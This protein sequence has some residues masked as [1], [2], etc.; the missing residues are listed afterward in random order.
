MRKAGALRRGLLVLCGLGSIGLAFVACTDT[1][2][3]RQVRL[4]TQTADGRILGNVMVRD[5]SGA[6]LGTTDPITGHLVI[7]VPRTTDDLSLWLSPQGLDPVSLSHA[8]GWLSVPAEVGF[9]HS[10]DAAS[11]TARLKLLPN[12]PSAAKEGK[13]EPIPA[14]PA[15]RDVWRSVPWTESDLPSGPEELAAATVLGSV[16]ADMASA[17]HAGKAGG[18][19]HS[20]EGEAQVSASNQILFGGSW[21]GMPFL[22]RIG[23]L[24]A[25]DEQVWRALKAAHLAGAAGALRA[26]ESAEAIRDSADPSGHS[27]GGSGHADRADVIETTSAQ[28]AQDGAAASRAGL[29][30]EASGEMETRS[31][32]TWPHSIDGGALEAASGDA[33]TASPLATQGGL[34]RGEKSQS[35]SEPA[36][37]LGLRTQGLSGGL[38][39][40][41]E[42]R[43]FQVSTFSGQPVVGALVSLI[44]TQKNWELAF[45]T[46]NSEGVAAGL[47]PSNTPFQLLRVEHAVSGSL[48]SPVT[49][50]SLSKPARVTFPA[51]DAGNDHPEKLGR[52]PHSPFSVSFRYPS[53]GRWKY[54]RGGSVEIVPRLINPQDDARSAA[55]VRPPLAPVVTALQTPMAWRQQMNSLSHFV[56]PASHWSNVD[57]GAHPSYSYVFR[58]AEERFSGSLP[59]FT[60]PDSS[61]PHLEIRALHQD[62]DRPRTTIWYPPSRELQMLDQ[63]LVGRFQRAI[64]ARFINA[65]VFLPVVPERVL[66]PDGE[67]DLSRFDWRSTPLDPEL[68]Y[69]V[70]LS[71]EKMRLNLEWRNREGRV[72]SSGRLPFPAGRPPEFFAN[73]VFNTIEENFPDELIVEVRSRYVSKQNSA[74]ESQP[75]EGKYLSVSTNREHFKGVVRLADTFHL[76]VIERNRLQAIATLRV[77][78]VEGGTVVLDGWSDAG[79]E[80]PAGPSFSAL[81]SRCP[82]LK[83]LVPNQDTPQVLAESD[84]DLNATL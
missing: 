84:F 32:S 4:I 47:V 39:F 53:H 44:S 72:C 83:P 57:L 3:I 51:P 34:S 80:L 38:E 24:R 56:V 28:S 79:I 67:L 22:G 55:S 18:M 65:R 11:H 37:A 6:V 20:P 2:E 58:F 59:P 33:D 48:L 7:Q 74:H 9:F 43:A 54:F 50:S 1:Q 5:P 31:G 63:T 69:V 8:P 21:A 66:D 26:S 27:E 77:S 46:T 76:Q 16:D 81:L 71:I 29:G 35:A 25:I 42:E 52:V 23:E 19:S 68:D 73:E 15:R 13:A 62:P 45:G 10:D 36:P 70:S 40:P 12:Q 82:P 61:R 64:K 17:Q 75:R 30:T 14:D 49:F 78:A 41:M 60:A